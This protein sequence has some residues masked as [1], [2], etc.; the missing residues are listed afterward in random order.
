MFDKSKNNK[1][2]IFDAAFIL[3]SE[4][5]YANVSMRDIANS[6]DVALSQVNYHYKSKEGLFK[7]VLIFVKDE[8]LQIIEKKLQTIDSTKDKVSFLIEYLQELIKTNTHIYTLILDFYSLSL[9]SDTFKEELKCFFKDISTVFEKYIKDDFIVNEN[10][11]EYSSHVLVR[12][13]IGAT[14]GVAMQ[15]ILIPDD[16]TILNGM[17]IFK[18]AIED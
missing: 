9:W 17:N 6:A 4:R 11:Q 16:K 12:M 1:D 14:F 7:E 13:I 10:I 2:R 5:G 8:Y 18:L 15:Y 3:I